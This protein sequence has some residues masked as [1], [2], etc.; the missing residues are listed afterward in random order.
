MASKRIELRKIILSLPVDGSITLNKPVYVADSEYP[1]HKWH[2]P[3]IR[4]ERWG[5]KGVAYA[6]DGINGWRL[7]ELSENEC[8]EILS[9]LN[10]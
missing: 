1:E 6:T 8:G 7:N 4:V 5:V 10:I 3:I 9:A 2:L